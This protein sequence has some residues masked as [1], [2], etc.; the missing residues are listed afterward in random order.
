M[1][2]K[3]LV[4]GIG[5]NTM[6]LLL[7]V[8]CSLVFALALDCQAQFTQGPPDNPSAAGL[9]TGNPPPTPAPP[10]AVSVP[11]SPPPFSGQQGV[12][13]PVPQSE[14]PVTSPERLLRAYGIPPLID[15]PA[16]DVLAHRLGLS[17]EQIRQIDA[18]RDD[19]YRRTRELRYEILRRRLEL[20]QL[21][22]DHRT[23]P[24]SITKRQRDLD[25]LWTRFADLS[26]A[27]AIQVRGLLKREQVEMLERLSIE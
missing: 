8:V 13:A 22:L 4:S 9:T 2:L 23:D 26:V 27:A 12:S 3:R 19:F 16:P 15:G 5:M 17:S 24:S 10:H 14:P 6:C 7:M 21:F 25:S 1:F 11:A 18:V 20:R